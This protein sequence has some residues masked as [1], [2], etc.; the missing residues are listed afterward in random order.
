MTAMEIAPLATPSQLPPAIK[1]LRYKAHRNH[2]FGDPALVEDQRRDQYR[3]YAER[4]GQYGIAERVGVDQRD[5][6]DR[7]RRRHQQ[8]ADVIDLVTPR[9]H[10]FLERDDQQRRGDD[11]E[12]DVEPENRLPAHMRRDQPS[13]HRPDDG[14]AAERAGN[15]ALHSGARFAAIDVGDHGLR[16][17]NQRAGA[18]ALHDAKRDQRNHVPRQPAQGGADKKDSRCRTAAPAF[19]RRDRTGGHKSE[20]G[21]PASAG[22]RRKSS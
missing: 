22:K 17:R 10:L 13:D 19:C 2:R 14:G 1:R 20:S 12:R 6:D 9:L 21:S 18:D 15:V 5:H 4:S 16:D 8:R 7:G 11:G 3:G